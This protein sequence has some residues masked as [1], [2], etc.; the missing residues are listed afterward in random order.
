M[1]PGLN[2]S[3]PVGG[4]R[5]GR[6]PGAR[7]VPR[8]IS[9]SASNI[10]RG[11]E[12]YFGFAAFRKRVTGFTVN[13][14]ITVPFSDS[15]AI[16]HHL[17]YADADSAGA[18]S[19]SRGGPGVGDGGADAAGQCRA[20]RSRSTASSSTGCSRSTSCSAASAL[21]GFGFSGNL[22]M[23]DQKGKGAAPGS[24]RRRGAAHLQRHALLREA[25]HQRARSRTTFTKGSQIAI[26]NQNGIPAPR[27]S[28]D[29]YQQWDFS[30]SLD[31]A[32]IFSWDTKLP[33]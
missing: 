27:C 2:F 32:Q 4:R 28:R 13:G 15:R 30:S 26:P 23:I 9:I 18:R 22:T 33:K 24:R 10:I 14:S 17:R 29:D 11:G 12:G 21:D 20:A 5:H 6:Q 25:R 7:A 3:S 16:R 1:L 8:T 19:M 31:L